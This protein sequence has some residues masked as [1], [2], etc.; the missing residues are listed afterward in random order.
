M[1]NCKYMRETWYGDSRDGKIQN[2][3]GFHY[4]KFDG[5]NKILEAFEFYQLYDGSTTVTPLPEMIGVSWT[6]DLGFENTETLD[7]I[8]AFDF[9]Q[10][11]KLSN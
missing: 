1:E 6:E 9:E 11:K 5:S 2:A 8:S 4:F 3:E 7:L 10:V